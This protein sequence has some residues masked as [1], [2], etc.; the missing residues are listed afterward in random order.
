MLNKKKS[1][2]VDRKYKTRQRLAK[3]EAPLEEQFQTA[4][5]LGKLYNF[6]YDQWQLHIQRFLSPIMVAASLIYKTK[7]VQIFI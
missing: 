1:K 5:V 4:R 7:S 6:F 2:K 3:V